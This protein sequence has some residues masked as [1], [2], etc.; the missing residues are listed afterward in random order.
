[1]KSELHSFSC[2][3]STLDNIRRIGRSYTDTISRSKENPDSLTCHPEWNETFAMRFYQLNIEWRAL[4]AQIRSEGVHEHKCLCETYDAEIKN[5][6]EE[7]YRTGRD[8][9]RDRLLKGI[10]ERRR[11]AREEEDGE[12]TS[13]VYFANLIH[14]NPL[15]IF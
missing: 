12:G 2:S 3:S 15:I 4:I 13:G 10:E 8:L 5:V 9:V 7:E 1:M 11:K 6:E 14:P